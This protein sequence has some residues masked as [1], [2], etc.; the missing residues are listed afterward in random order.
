[1]TN[2]GV[3]QSEGLESSLKVTAFKNQD[4]D[5]TVGG[6]YTYLN[7]TVLSITSLVPTLTLATSGNAA[8]QV[9]AGQAFPVITG[10]DYVRDPK[11]RV[12]VDGTSGLPTQS[13]NVVILGNASP[14]T[15][16]GANGSV[17]YKNI[18]FS[19]LF[20][21]RGGYK[22]YNGV[23]PELD[24]SGTSYRSGL[25]NRQS[26]VF[27]NSV[28]QNPDGSFS[29]NKSVAIMN[30]NGNNGFW[31]DGINRGVVSNYVTSGDFIKLREISIG[32][33]LTPFLT[34]FGSKFIK[35]GDISIQGRN[36]FLWMAKDN[37]YTDPEY[38]VASSNGRN[39]TGLNDLSTT[40]PVRTYGATL[41]L[42]F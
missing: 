37:Y 17:S 23:G 5:V 4:W 7:N 42:K 24:W 21:Y 40:P 22:V 25:Y 15:I 16:I 27:P 26:F 28:L 41:N 18:K 2:V 3:T 14:K 19:I 6:N 38:S 39:G 13:S 8:S 32:Y 31:S 1:L 36:L 30:G 12:I 35:G 34:S 29:Q 33:N 10:Y 11:G 20:E 9:Y